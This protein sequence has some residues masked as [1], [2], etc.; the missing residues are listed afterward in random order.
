MSDRLLTSPTIWCAISGHGFGHAAQV[1][2]VLNELGRRL[3][4]LTAIL[5]TTVSSSF[6]HDRL[7][8]AWSQHSVQQDVGC[9]QHGPLQIDVSDTWAKHQQFH[10][11]WEARLA[12][13]VSAMAAAAPSLVLADTPYLALSAGKRAGIPTV[14]L[15]SLTWSE[16]LMSLDH[17][18]AEHRPLLRSIELAYGEADL[19]LRMAPGLPLS[20]IKNVLDIGPITEP[21]LSERE[22]LRSFLKITGS[23]QLVLV[24]FGGIPL[25]SL[26]WAQ[27]DK[28]IG[29]QFL[30]DG[31][32][33][34][35][36]SRVHSLAAIPFTFKSALASVDVVMTKPGYGTI[37][38]A[39]ALGLPVVYVRR[40]NFAEEAPLVE[41]LHQQGQGRELSLQDFLS[42]N[43]RP[44]LEPLAGIRPAPRSKF[45]TGAMD[46]ASSL[47]RYF[48]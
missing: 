48:Q 43:W 13:E 40:Y 1:V 38:E 23:E 46:A 21:A 6:F 20:G 19:A 11:T 22:R 47:L 3:P 42:G 7:A 37:V 8:I 10:A 17:S 27:M 15:A 14:L 16:I 12:G 25:E 4:G 33:P 26:P 9:V 30:V 18:A 34:G 36:S 39:V 28:M 44:A 5:R 41:F 29:Y 35:G 45:M 31:P 24:G 32:S 2:P